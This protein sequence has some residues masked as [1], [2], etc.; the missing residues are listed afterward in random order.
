MESVIRYT[1]RLWKA[2]ERPPRPRR[3]PPLASVR[4]R[5]AP[6]LATLTRDGDH[7]YAVAVAANSGLSLVFEVS[8]VERFKP[9]ML[10][11]LCALFDD[12]DLPLIHLPLEGADIESAAFVRL[13]DPGA[14]SDL[15]DVR[16]ICELD[17]S[18]FPNDPRCVQLKLNDYPRQHQYP[19]EPCAA[20]PLLF[21]AGPVRTSVH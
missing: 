2:L 6:W 9:A 3:S 7:Q 10:A 8:S 1:D 14:S 5:L 21:G 13:R 4:G 17:F 19:F 11:A 15:A 12:L 16:S 18:F 20:A